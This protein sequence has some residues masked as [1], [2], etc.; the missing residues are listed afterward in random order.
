LTT[1]HDAPLGRDDTDGVIHV[2]RA[3]DL[4]IRGGNTI[5]PVV[6]EHALLAHPQVTGAT[7]VGGLDRYP[8]RW[9]F[10]QAQR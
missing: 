1:D 8:L 2:G 9:R 4:I 5:D 6:I 3:R 10:S 7:A